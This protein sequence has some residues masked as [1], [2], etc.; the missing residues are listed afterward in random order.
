MLELRQASAG[1][2]GAWERGG[3][4]TLFFAGFGRRLVTSLL[5]FGL[6][7]EWLLPLRQLAAYTELYR[8]GPLIAA[9]GLFLAVGLFMPPT[10]VTL[11]LSFVISAAAVLYL[12]GGESG[13]FTAAIAHLAEALRGDAERAA[14]GD[15]QL[16]GESRTLLLLVGLSMMAAAV[17]SLVWLRQWGLGLTAL[18]AVYLMLLY[19][20]L[21]IDVLPGL[22]RTCAEGLTL[23]GLL[24]V[25]RLERLAGAPFTLGLRGARTIA[26]WPARW[27]AGAAWIAVLAAVVGIGAA[28][29]GGFSSEPAPWAAQAIDWGKAELGKEQP[30]SVAAGGIGAGGW[31]S[32]DVPSGG[33]GRTTGYGFDDRTLGAP[34]KPDN[35]VLFTVQSPEKEYLRGDSKSFYDGKGWEQPAHRLEARTI[36]PQ[37]GG[38]SGGA[39][40]VDGSAGAGG[41]AASRTAE[42]PQRM[43]VKAAAPAPGW[44]LFAAG[45]EAR[46]TSLTTAGG[47]R[48]DGYLTD[49]ETGALFPL[50]GSDRVADY[51]VETAALAAD[52]KALQQAAAASGGDPAGLAAAYTQLPA[53]LPARV[54]SLAR[55]I[56]AKAG[57]TRYDK[58]KAVEA[59]LRTHYAYTLTQTAVPPAGAD[60]VDDFLFDQKQGY[61]VHFA[62]AMA[63][64]LRTQGIPARYVK[65]FAPGETVGAAGGR[66]AAEAAGS[67]PAEHAYTV[68]ASDAHAWV[69]VFFPGAGWLPFEPTPGFAAPAGEPGAADAAAPAAVPAGA[70]YGAGAGEAAAPDAAGAIRRAAADLQAAAVR[71]AGAAA[72]GAQAHAREARGAAAGPWA[73]AAPAAGA[74]AAAV[75]AAA[76]RRRRE[77]F[78]FAGALRKYRS[79]LGAGRG[80]A[81]RGQFLALADG[82]WRELY[83][84]CGERPPH[85]TPREYA[86]SLRLPPPAA[87]LLADFVRWDEAARYGAEWRERPAPEQIG[88]LLRALRAMP[89]RPRR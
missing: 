75:L 16:S 87:G 38:P 82:C 17:Q 50:D 44:P 42:A 8:I 26:G 88:A 24:A 51:T 10:R 56:M 63:V 29:G 41:K 15:F 36:V 49:T 13:S 57:D 33:A 12:F 46:V 39:S 86:A 6:M 55:D 11:P 32:L 61:C 84:R 23:A 25:P 77:R 71:A 62:S 89:E 30:A 73:W 69:E 70:Q 20:F 60:F 59:Y 53:S 54:G 7:T 76:A 5:L 27:W 85:R 72:R 28:W 64:L 78:A 35:S 4:G 83:R 2:P 40:A 9:V 43:T 65:G 74:A 19:G 58:V 45:P 68:R 37:A 52:P 31:P 18:T 66:D 34:I 1:K 79:A 80:T 21:G 3:D 47:S 48:A 14:H 81:A 22:L 67:Q